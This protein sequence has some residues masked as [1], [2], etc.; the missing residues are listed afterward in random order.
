MLMCAGVPLTAAPE[1]IRP[2]RHFSCAPRAKCENAW[3]RCE[4][5]SPTLT[6]QRTLAACL[7]SPPQNLVVQ[8]DSENGATR[9][10]LLASSARVNYV[11]PAT[12]VRWRGSRR[13][14]AYGM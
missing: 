13:G 5:P 12:Q 3:S 9:T 4:R 8:P 2:R 6:E 11:V 1:L 14:E 10:A 7:E